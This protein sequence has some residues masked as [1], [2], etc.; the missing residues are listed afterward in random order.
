MQVPGDVELRPIEPLLPIPQQVADSR[1]TGKYEVPRPQRLVAA[2]EVSER[3]AAVQAQVS[4]CAQQT[5]VLFGLFGVVDESVSGIVQQVERQTEDLRRIA[6]T[7]DRAN[8]CVDGVAEQIEAA[9]E[10]VL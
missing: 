8:E 2:E 3:V 9:A 10:L 1:A 6:E 7:A 5:D 4:A